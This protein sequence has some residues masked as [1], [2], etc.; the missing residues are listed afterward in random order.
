MHRPWL[1]PIGAKHGREKAAWF[2]IAMVMLAP[3]AVGLQILDSFVSGVP[4]ITTRDAR[5]GPEIGYLESGVNGEMTDSNTKDF[6][7]VVTTMILD[8]G[9]RA[10]L[11]AAAATASE[12][13][14]LSAM[15]GRFATGIQDCLSNAPRRS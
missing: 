10:R 3:G 1:H 5:H 2:R 8:V 14:T 9:Y 6:A 12:R 11:S 7:D 15:V 13:Y 4:L